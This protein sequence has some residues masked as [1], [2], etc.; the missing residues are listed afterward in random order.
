MGS[1]EAQWFNFDL[2]QF[3][4]KVMV[5]MDICCHFELHQPL[6]YRFHFVV[7]SLNH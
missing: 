6:F 3:S 5:S 4:P 7:L 1:L 2:I